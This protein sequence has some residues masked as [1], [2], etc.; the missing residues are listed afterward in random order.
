MYKLAGMKFIGLMNASD[1]ADWNENMKTTASSMLGK[2]I[3]A[4]YIFRL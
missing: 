4:L 2:Y 1:F 3:K